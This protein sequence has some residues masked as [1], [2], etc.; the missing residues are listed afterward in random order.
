[1]YFVKCDDQFLLNPNNDNFSLI[2]AV[3]NLEENNSGSMDFKISHKHPNIDV[4]EKMK[5][6][7]IVYQDDEEIWSGRITEEKVDFWKNHTYHV[8]GELSF[9]NDSI[10]NQNKYQNVTPESFFRSLISNHNS[11]VTPEKQFEVG[12]VSVVD[13]NDSIYH[14][15]NY[16]TTLN[17]IQEKIIKTLGGFIRIRHENGK[18]IIDLLGERPNTNEQIIRFGDNLIDFTKNYDFKDL[19]TVIIPLG[20][21]IEGS[22]DDGLDDYVTIESVN[23]GKNYVESPDAVSKYGRIEKVVK[24]SDVVTPSILKSKAEKHLKDNQFDD[25]TLEVKAIDLH[26]LDVNEERVKISDRIRVISDIHGL[27]R[28]FPVTKLTIDLLSP[29]KN[30]FTLGSKVNVSLSSKQKENQSSIEKAIEKVKNITV[31]SDIIKQAVDGASALLKDLTHGFVITEKDRIMIMDTDNEETASKKWLWNLNGLGY[32]GDGGNSYETAL[33][34]DGHI[35]GKMISANSIESEHLSVGCHA[36]LE[37]HA[38]NY[39]TEQTKTIRSD[40]LKETDDKLTGYYSKVDVDQKLSTGLQNVT[41]EIS[42][43]YVKND[44]LGNYVR[45]DELSTA[46]E[47]NADSIVTRVKNDLNEELYDFL[48]K[49]LNDLESQ[50][51]SFYVGSTAWDDFIHLQDVSYDLD[52]ETLTR[53]NSIYISGQNDENGKYST[54]E[55][56]INIPDS[57]TTEAEKRD[58]IITI[59][60]RFSKDFQY[61]IDNYPNSSWPIQ[62]NAQKNRWHWEIKHMTPQLQ[63]A[64]ANEVVKFSYKIND[65]SAGKIRFQSIPTVDTEILDLHFETPR[66]IYQESLLKQTAEGLSS[67]VQKGDVIS[68]INQSAESV[69]ISASKID[70][71]GDTA[72]HGSF[73]SDSGAGKMVISNGHIDGYYNNKLTLQFHPNVAWGSS[74]YSGGHLS[75][76]EEGFDPFSSDNDKTW[77]SISKDSYFKQ[78]TC[79]RGLSGTGLYVNGDAWFFGNVKAETGGTQFISDRRLKH[80]IETL[81]NSI[82]LI[83]KLRP[84]KFKYNNGTSDRFH[85]GFIAQE[86]RDAIEGDDFGVWCYDKTE[87]INF[88]RYDE[89]IADLVGSVQYLNNKVN[90]LENKLKERD[91]E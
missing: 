1:M 40:I 84:V 37:S 31:G 64:K 65:S 67:C 41:S 73:E 18:R 86:V 34:M 11:K 83:T 75:I 81:D 80:D 7:I 79:G 78:V 30:T 59:T 3:L 62:F 10:Q 36:E 5:S 2:S 60:Y 71:S 38:E 12:V 88:I 23:D 49:G 16:E 57:I 91:S 42:Q 8:E 51:A 77:A 29:S 48:P 50:N 90:D 4:I 47:Q 53:N 33:T 58:L 19:A 85:H 13:N 66:K 82:D 43:K 45:T 63:N 21:I 22:G 24:W 35:N 20:K 87:D 15:T 17:C 6:E 46:I 56:G 26:N 14:Y 28:Y 68:S 69:S 74:G 27:D 61:I 9:L 70:F 72:I 55:C 89:L 25:M 76:G 44:E 54:R 39:V 52:G 32:S